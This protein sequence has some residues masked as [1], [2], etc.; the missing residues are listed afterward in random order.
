MDYKTAADCGSLRDEDA[1]LPLHT[2]IS[3]WL[4]LLAC[5]A[6]ARE[7]RYLRR[8]KE[9]MKT[10]FLPS[11]PDFE[12]LI[13]ERVNGEA[14]TGET[15]GVQ[16]GFSFRLWVIIGFFMLLSLSSAFFG[17]NFAQIAASEGMSFLLPVGITVGMVLTC[18]G[19]LFIGSHLGELSD[20]FGLR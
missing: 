18:Y 4:H 7:Q 2:Q 16:A 3:L 20:R 12:E 17:M 5:P 15:S 9:I 10:D 11:S 8:I 1:Y 13:M 19:A 6:C 14:G